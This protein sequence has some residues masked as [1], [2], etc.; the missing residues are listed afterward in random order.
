MILPWS[1]VL[2]VAGAAWGAD[3]TGYTLAA[4]IFVEPKLENPGF[5]EG[6]R[7]WDLPEGYRHD[8]RGGRSGT[9][10]LRLDRA[11][12]KRYTLASQAIFLQ[13]GVRY[14]FGAWVR[15]ANVEGGDSGA[16]I[17]LEFHDKDGWMGGHYPAGIKGTRDW[18]WVEGNGAVPDAAVRCTL[19][20]YL[21]QNMTGTAWF[22]DVRIKAEAGTWSACQLFP[23]HGRIDPE[24]GRIVLGSY[25]N[26]RFVAEP[27]RIEESDL[28]CVIRAV[29]NKRTLME[30]QAQVRGSRIAVD[31]GALPAGDISLDLK[32]LE[33]RRKWIIGQA[34]LPATVAAAGA[35]P[36][37]SCRL[38]AFGRAI[39]NGEPFLPVGLY[40]SSLKRADIA[41]LAESPFNCVMPYGSME[42]KL[43]ESS[44]DGVAAIREALD[45]CHA[46]GLKV[47][48]SIKDVFA[49]TPW[50]K[51]AFFGARGE[52]AVIEKTVR[53]FRDHPALLAWYVNDELPVSVLPRLTARRQ[54]VNRLD[55]HHPTWAVLY[56]FDELQ[57]YAPTCDILG[58]D[59]YPIENDRS[60][61]MKR[62]LHGME[63]SEEA[64]GTAEG[65][66]LW[67]VPQVFN[68][69]AYGC[70]D[71]ETLLK[72]YRDPTETEMRAMALLCALKGAKGFIFYSYFDLFRP[73]TLPDLERRWPEICRV[74]R[75]LRELEPFLLSPR[76][77]PKTTVEAGSGRVLARCFV[78]ED[79]RW[80]VLVAGIGP[81]DSAATIHVE[82]APG[83]RSRFGSSKPLGQGRYRFTGR[84]ICA[85][86]LEEQ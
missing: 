13:P 52:E 4:P 8:P 81:G 6:T 44:L 30:T 76:P 64:T 51:T 85:D 42:L 77:H 74:G 31:L 27:E 41:R 35:P 38:D 86:V 48:F 57:Y 20:L 24:R 2:A 39:V 60:R 84:D 40:C 21:R 25:I 5:D 53:S 15:T 17:C 54:E 78:S 29:R 18:T 43:D 46:G 33:T 12:P 66:A 67:V 19:V 45:A 28:A 55:P 23:S 7:D 63:K 32:L 71:R 72:N 16:T 75:Q 11:D 36:P 50:E 65:M 3:L 79:G 68:S 1:V 47:I 10:A 58:I 73:H 70:D 83:L 14:T 59:P 80:R 82:G 62:V 56:Q 22:D 26:G 37:D 9:G 69:G 61:D 49:G 34:A